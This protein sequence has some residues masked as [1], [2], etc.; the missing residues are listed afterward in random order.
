MKTPLSWLRDFTPLPDD[1]QLIVDSCNELGFVVDGVEHIGQGLDD[2]IV[3][4][5]QEVHAIDGA[6]RIRRIVVDDGSGA[7]FDVVCGAWNFEAGDHVAFTPAGGT[8]PDGFQIT[9]RKMKGVTSNGMICSARELGLGTDGDGILKLPATQPAGTPLADA[10]DIERDVVLDLDIETNRPDALSMAGVARDLAAKLAL[11]FSIPEPPAVK[12]GGTPPALRVESP[13]LAARFTAT[14][15]HG[16]RLGDSPAWMARRLTLAGMRPINNLVDISNYVML[17][18]GQPTH[19]YD[20]DR[21]PGG[22]LSVRRANPGEVVVTLDGVERTLGDGDDCLI[23]D[24]EGTP[25]GIAG[26]M[27]GASSEISAAT[28]TVL[29]EAAWFQPMAIARTAKRIGLRSEASAR[30]ERGVDHAGVDRAVARYVQLATE[31]AGASVGGAADFRDDAHLPN[32]APIRLRTARVNEILGTALTDDEIKRYLD[33]IGFTAT[34]AEPG[35]HEVVVPTFRPDVNAGEINLIEEIARH[36]GYDEIPKTLPA[37]PRMGGL[38]PY[39]RERRLVREVLVGAGLSEAVTS[40]LIGPGDHERA[41]LAEDGIEADRPM[42][43]EESVLRMSMLPGLLRAVAFN[44]AHRNGDVAVFETGPVFRRPDTPQPLPD[45]RERVSAVLAGTD[46]TEAVHVLHTVLD[47]LRVADV[48][49]VAAP[50]AGG[51][52]GRSAQVT[53]SGNPVGVVGEVDPDVVTAWDIEGRIGWIDLDL[54]AL[55]EAPRRPS[56]M[57]PVS[58]F[59]SSDIDLAFVVDE[60]IPAGAVEATLRS[61]AGD[62]LADL[63]LFDVYRGAGLPDGTRSL[64]YRLRFQAQDHTLTDDEVGGVRQRC[65]DAVT[66]AHAATLRG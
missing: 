19:P 10:L 36:H 64:A 43:R 29:L 41:G 13:D 51:H 9:R 24:A 42:L 47:A 20:L 62:L 53:A 50:F 15:L 33:P 25:V 32:V 6:D 21:L 40:V 57:V 54:G 4:V 28:T 38:T 55:H 23:C 49:L 39:Q 63:A 7:P 12:A 37:S 14:V 8:L 61:A 3:A 58:R 17:E 22:G 2:V 56:E 27:G 48:E 52:P 65:I 1:V 44:A 5:A 35:I 18:L 46:A 16:A 30:F 45:E 66:Q 31:L 59:P 60:A 34:P 11:P 26:V